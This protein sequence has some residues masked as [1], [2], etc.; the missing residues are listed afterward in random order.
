MIKIITIEPNQRIKNKGP[1][2]K[3]A[4]CGSRFTETRMCA[5]YTNDISRHHF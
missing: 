4:E 1:G 5:K 2:R 3:K